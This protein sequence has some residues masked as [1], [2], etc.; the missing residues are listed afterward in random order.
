[1]LSLQPLCSLTSL[2]ALNFEAKISLRQ[3]A[4]DK[5]SELPAMAVSDGEFEKWDKEQRNKTQWKSA[6]ANNTVY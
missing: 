4:F 1:M 2:P 5:E 3:H 6:S